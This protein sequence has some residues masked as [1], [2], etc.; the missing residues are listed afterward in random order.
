MSKIIYDIY[1]IV[2]NKRSNNKSSEI[3]IYN[4]QIYF[5]INDTNL[6]LRSIPSKLRKNF[7]I[8]SARLETNIN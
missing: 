4:N 7:K 6:V 5:N 3:K 1:I 2:S 8:L